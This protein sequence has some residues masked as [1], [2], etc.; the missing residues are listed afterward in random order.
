MIPHGE[1]IDIVI[2]IEPQ[3]PVEAANGIYKGMHACF[4]RIYANSST[5]HRDYTFDA[6]IIG[7][8]SCLDEF[9]VSF[10]CR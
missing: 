6:N 3:M 7:S 1:G 2:M 5:G 4:C 9:T 8:D 10:Y